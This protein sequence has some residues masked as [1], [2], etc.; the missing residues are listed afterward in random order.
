MNALTGFSARK[1][2]TPMGGPKLRLRIENAG[3]EIDIALAA[4]GVGKRRRDFLAAFL[5]IVKRRPII[6]RA[7][8]EERSEGGRI[9]RLPGLPIRTQPGFKVLFCDGHF[10]RLLISERFYRIE[11]RCAPRGIDRRDE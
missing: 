8:C 6:K 5:R 10:I 9:A 11:A 7:L 2:A 3:A 4:D 1:G